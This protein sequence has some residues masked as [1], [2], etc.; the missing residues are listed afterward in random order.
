MIHV[1]CLIRGSKPHSAAVAVKAEYAGL[2]THNRMERPEY[3]VTVTQLEVI[4]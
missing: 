4:S 1:N 2:Q 3:I